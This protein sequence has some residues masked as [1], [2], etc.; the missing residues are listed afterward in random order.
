[1]F[2]RPLV[3]QLTR[4][5]LEERN[6]LRLGSWVSRSEEA[7]ETSDTHVDFGQ[8]NKPLRSQGGLRLVT[9]HDFRPPSLSNTAVVTRNCPMRTRAGRMRRMNQLL[10]VPGLMIQWLLALKVQPCEHVRG[11]SRGMMC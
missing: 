5:A 2:Q 3:E 7:C 8:N 1:V 10:V 9:Q 4:L 11:A 6:W